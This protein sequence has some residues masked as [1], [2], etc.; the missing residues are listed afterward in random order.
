MI[1]RVIGIAAAVALS[2]CGTP[3]AIVAEEPVSVEPTLAPRTTL[4]ARSLQPPFQHNEEG[5]PDVV[6][7]PCTWVPDE[8]VR[9]L[10]FD[11]G[12][13][14]RVDLVAERTTLAC[15]VR[16]SGRGLLL[17]SG[18][19]P[20]ETEL[21][22]Y[23]DRIQQTTEINGRAAFVVPDDVNADM[24][25]VI[26][27]T[28]VGAVTVARTIFANTTTPCDGIVEFATKIEETIGA[29]N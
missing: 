20:Y 28:A 1:R 15:I 23:R 9:D 13:R 21:E 3:N 29:A 10:G 6:Y 22:R 24:C 5:R 27:K 11:P 2:G 26:M 12:T 4:T 14:E 19:I 25:F 16:S 8:L 7:D 17:R 18:N